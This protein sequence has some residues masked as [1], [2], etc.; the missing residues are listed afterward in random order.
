MTYPRC[1]VYH[2]TFVQYPTCKEVWSTATHFA[3]LPLPAT[4]H[5][6]TAP[7]FPYSH[8]PPDV[9]RAPEPQPPYSDAETPTRA[10]LACVYRTWDIHDKA[11]SLSAGSGGTVHRTTQGWQPR[12]GADRGGKGAGHAPKSHTDRLKSPMVYHSMLHTYSQDHCWKR[13]IQ[14]V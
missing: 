11:G 1:R 3:L 10:R 5:G 8:G 2:L 4:R 12:W 7:Y 6:H 14:E 9:Q 13:S